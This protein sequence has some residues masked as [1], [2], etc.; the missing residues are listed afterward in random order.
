MKKANQYF[1][2]HTYKFDRNQNNIISNF[3]IYCLSS[4]VGSIFSVLLS[5][6]FV[7][8]VISIARKKLAIAADRRVVIV[9]VAFASYPIAEFLAALVNKGGI[10]GVIASMGALLFLSV[11]PLVSR[12]ALSSPQDLVDTTGIGAAAGAVLA[13]AFCLVQILFLDMT[14]PEAGFGNAAVAGA[15]SLTVC[16]VC[17][18]LLPAVQAYLRNF[19]IAGIV[20]SLITIVLSGTRAVWLAAPFS[21][22][23]AAFPLFRFKEKIVFGYKSIVLAVITG[24]SL[25]FLYNILDRQIRAALSIVQIDGNNTLYPFIDH[26]LFLW[27]GGWEQ[28][29]ASWLFGYGPSSSS[30]MI[31]ALGGEP[32]LIYTH[33]HNIFLTA[34]MRGGVIEFAS[35]LLVFSVLVWFSVFHKP[36]N[37]FQFTGQVLISSCLVATVIPGM[38]GTVFTN[39]ILLAVFIYTMIIGICLG[40]SKD[41]SSTPASSFASAFHK[42]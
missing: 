25:P 28:V 30:D 6:S 18:V 29:K 2:N 34:L 20:C 11:I 41:V 10:E 13:L 3:S 40:I 15:V 37:H 17:L 1:F 19:I 39:D 38:A 26:R 35:L 4:L 9:A 27:S 24:S 23:I 7:W 31:L 42:A 8:A 33:Y 5:V 21:I 16:C 22:A 14:R 32:P 12:L 36:L